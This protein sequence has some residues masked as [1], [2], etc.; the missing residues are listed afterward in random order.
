MIRLYDLVLR[1]CPN[2]NP[3]APRKKE[4]A[5]EV[6]AAIVAGV[7]ALASSVMSSASQASANKTN[8]GIA[9]SNLQAQ[10]ETNQA[11]ERIADRTNA[12]NRLMMQEQNAF[13]LDMWN[14]QNQYNEPRAQV[15]RLL[16]AGIN[17]ASG[18]GKVTEAGQLSSADWAGAQASYNTAPQLNYHQQPINYDF[19]GVGNA[20]MQA[21]AMKQSQ[22]VSESQ[23]NYNNAKADYERA[24]AMSRLQQEANN[25]ERGSIEREMAQRQLDMFNAT[26]E[27]QKRATENTAEM[28]DREVERIFEE[29]R[30]YQLRNDILEIERQYAGKLKEAELNQINRTISQIDAQIG[31][32]NSNRLLT[33]AQRA[34]EIERQIGIKIDNGLKG[35]DYEVQKSIKN[36]IIDSYRWNSHRDKWNAVDA[37]MHSGRGFG[38]TDRPLWQGFVDTADKFENYTRRFGKNRLVGK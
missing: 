12:M 20:A 7:A 27:A 36:A 35:V 11:N 15:N 14:K 24:S 1:D 10:R 28:S 16:A 21:I 30:S 37:F 32:I 19:N 17:P 8:L 31:L 29:T 25:A 9:E 34:S 5:A 26:F 3:F 2:G 22:M 4:I 18:F 23:A 38:S 33:D 13:N 6:G